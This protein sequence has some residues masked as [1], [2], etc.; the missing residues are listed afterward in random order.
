MRRPKYKT[1]RPR[2]PRRIVRTRGRRGVGAGD[3]ENGRKVPLWAAMLA[4]VGTAF[5]FGKGR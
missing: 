2:L 5:Y 4:L 3:D 1:R